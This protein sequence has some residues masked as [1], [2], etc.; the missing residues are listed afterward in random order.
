[1]KKE[2]I[3]A[4]K[5]KGKS[6]LWCVRLKRIKTQKCYWTLHFTPSIKEKQYKYKIAKNEKVK[7]LYKLILYVT[8]TDSNIIL[9][10]IKG[11]EDTQISQ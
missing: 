6:Y 8:Q 5:F 4:D 2:E 1:M 7:K 9:C 10:R 11:W 3:L